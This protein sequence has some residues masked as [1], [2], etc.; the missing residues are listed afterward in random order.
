MATATVSGRRARRVTTTT[1]KDYGLGHVAGV[2][3]HDSH[4]PD[5]SVQ[6][7]LPWLTERLFR[8]S[9]ADGTGRIVQVGR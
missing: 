6:L 8:F 7:S 9:L 2:F 4:V 3:Y 5:S 1:V